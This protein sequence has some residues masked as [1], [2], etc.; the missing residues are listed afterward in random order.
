MVPWASSPLLHM[1]DLQ[2]LAPDTES[3]IFRYLRKPS[4]P[5][6]AADPT[7]ATEDMWNPPKNNSPREHKRGFGFGLQLITS[8]PI[9]RLPQSINDSNNEC[10]RSRTSGTVGFARNEQYNPLPCSL[11]ACT[12][13]GQR[14][15]YPGTY[16]RR[17]QL[18]APGT[19]ERAR[20]DQH[21]SPP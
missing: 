14:W 17:M 11:R 1:C 6:K 3:P 21:K 9:A 20:R 10:R 5:H 7:P 15:P 4:L 12:A 16:T 2:L 13:A 8:Q 19:P 18:V